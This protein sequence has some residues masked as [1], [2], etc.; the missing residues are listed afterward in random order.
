VHV[1]TIGGELQAAGSEASL[2]R[3]HVNRCLTSSASPHL[4]VG[5]TPNGGD[6]AGE[7][8]NTDA[9]G[10]GISEG[11][12]GSAASRGQQKACLQRYRQASAEIMRVLA[13][14]GREGLVSTTLLHCRY[15]DQSCGAW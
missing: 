1:Q 8:G 11:A 2:C 14:V 3:C 9:R 4:S 5:T 13:K 7:A 6:T 12:E 10:T 15:G